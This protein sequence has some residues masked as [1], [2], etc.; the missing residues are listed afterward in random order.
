M[1]RKAVIQPLTLPAG[2]RVLAVSD[3]H[4]NL[5]FLK[6]LL[7]KVNFTPADILILVGDLVEKGPDSLGAL[8]YVMELARTHTV[9]A[10]SGNCDDLIPAFLDRGDGREKQ[11]FH[12]YISVWR[13]RS[14]LYQMAAEAGAEIQDPDDLIGLRD[15]LRARFPRELAFL[16]SLP[17]VLLSD[18][19]L[20]VH[21][22]VPREDRLEDLDAWQCMKN[23]DFRSQGHSF[24]RWVVV[25]HWPVTLY[26]PAIP[27]AR[28][29]LDLDAHIASIDGGCVLK[30]DGQLNALILPDGTCTDPAAFADM[31]YDGLP[32]AVALDRQEASSDS[33]NVRWSEHAVAVL[34][35]G[36]EFCRCRHEASGRELDILTSFLRKKNGAVICEDATDYR[37]PV[38]PGDRLHVVRRTSRGTLAKK[39]G[40]T[41]WYHGRLLE[42]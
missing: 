24:R 19:F 34:E 13:E 30:L 27:S 6:G 16:R 32:S 37:L 5:T 1:E 2:R 41:G 18:K 25:G 17:T 28:P 22:G 33:I 3:I 10:V 20:F 11:F 31:A 36:E 23:D 15:L 39:D 4:G 40:V 35:R 9:Y 14:L 7:R 42:T 21:G 38:E 29:L 8:R 12:H 26:D